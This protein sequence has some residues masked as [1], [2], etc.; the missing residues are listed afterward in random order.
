[1]T[2]GAGQEKTTPA[3]ND[4]GGNWESYRWDMT[5]NIFIRRSVTI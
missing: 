3:V 5:I 4:L 2:A 1:V